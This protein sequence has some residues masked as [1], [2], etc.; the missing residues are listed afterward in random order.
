MAEMPASKTHRAMHYYDTG[1]SMTPLLTQDPQSSF[2]KSKYVMGKW[3]WTAVTWDPSTS[4]VLYDIRVG[5]EK[6]ARADCWV[7]LP[8]EIITAYVAKGLF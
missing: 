3:N 1:E 7:G 6:R 8:L 4:V 5:K 2:G